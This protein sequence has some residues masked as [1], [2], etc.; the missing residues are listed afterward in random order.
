[1]VSL[2]ALAIGVDT[3]F[4]RDLDAD[5]RT[6]ARSGSVDFE[7]S[8]RTTFEDGEEEDTV[9]GGEAWRSGKRFVRSRIGLQHL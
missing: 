3:G 8:E 1:M 9:D 6:S 4:A 7:L 5:G 2:V